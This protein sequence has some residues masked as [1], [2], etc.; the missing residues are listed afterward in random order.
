VLRNH[1][2]RQADFEES[3]RKVALAIENLTQLAITTDGR[4]DIL[5]EGQTHTDARLDALIDAQIQ[6]TQ[7][8]DT[9]TNNLNTLTFRVDTLTSDI[10]A[11]NGR[12]YRID[13]RLDR[14]GEH[15]DRLTGH[16]EILN[17]RANRTDARIDQV[18]ILQAENAELMKRTD[19]Q[20]RALVAA[21][22]STIR[23]PKTVKKVRKSS[24]KGSA[25]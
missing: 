17:D 5:E 24:K 6:L 21:Q 12:V 16:A 11:V 22:A 4:L 3:F 20:I 25:K 19:N 10:A 8:V 13:E 23:K 18:A 7:K 9:L 2:A 14:I 15:I 1:E